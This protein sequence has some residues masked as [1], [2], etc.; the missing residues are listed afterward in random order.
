MRLTVDRPE[1]FEVITQIYAALYRPE[2]HFILKDV[3]AFIA[4][5][6]K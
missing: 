1:D 5:K 4:A 2:R 3:L 6:P